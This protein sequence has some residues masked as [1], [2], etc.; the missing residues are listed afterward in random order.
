MTGRVWR[1][2]VAQADQVDLADLSELAADTEQLVWFDLVGPEHEHLQR[3]A[4]ELGLDPHAIEDAVAHAERP[5]ATRHA[6]HTFVTAYA[7]SFDE[8]R[9]VDRHA[10]RLVVHKVSAFVLPRVLITVRPD[11]S[12]PMDRVVERWDDTGD[13]LSG[14]HAIGA[15]L[16]GLLDVVVDA[17]FA[18]IEELDDAIEDIE[19]LLFDA[20]VSTGDVQRRVYRMRKELVQVRRFVL[21][22]REVVNTVLRHRHDVGLDNGDPLAGYY[23][24]LY[25]HVL[26]AAEWTESL[27][28]MVTTVFETNLSLQDAHLN[29]VMKKLA[30]WAAIIAVPTAVT[31]WYGQN[32]PY[33]GFESSFGLWQS[34]LLVVGASVVLY[35]VFRRKD[36][37]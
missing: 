28:D 35:V 2:G 9:D 34:I 15:L 17:H 14:R 6:S 18:T 36:W 5:K 19:N 25:D 29:R 16:H 8:G 21:P 3:L 12:F 31:G 32:L 7:T 11:A 23:D 13:L 20:G 26:R 30:G 33:P 24:D 27:R 37:L 4:D 10:S 1:G 22:M